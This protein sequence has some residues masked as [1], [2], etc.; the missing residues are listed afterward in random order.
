MGLGSLLDRRPFL[1]VI[2]HRGDGNA[3]DHFRVEE[4]DKIPRPLLTLIHRCLDPAV[5]GFELV[6]KPLDERRP[7]FAIYNY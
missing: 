6:A 4:L 2:R 3:R 7:S 1:G 5:L